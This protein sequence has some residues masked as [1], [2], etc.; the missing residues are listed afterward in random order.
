MNYEKLFE[1]I[2]FE[3]R[4]KPL[5]EQVLREAAAKMSDNVGSKYVHALYS[6][7]LNSNKNGVKANG[8]LVFHSIR[9]KFL[10]AFVN[11][12][13]SG[14]NENIDTEISNEQ[15][16]SIKNNFSEQFIE[17]FE[18]G[19]SKNEPRVSRDALSN[20]LAYTLKRNRI[21]YNGVT[22]ENAE[23]PNYEWLLNS[24]TSS[25]G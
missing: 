7:A 8:D 19:Y 9:D 14:F 15:K 25:S 4:L 21:S 3:Y 22:Y 24:S 5:F 6:K 12:D 18:S 1:E 23:N 16:T 10:P 13:L 20:F 17:E 2:Y 11:L